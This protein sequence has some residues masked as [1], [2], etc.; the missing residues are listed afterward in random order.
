MAYFSKGAAVFEVF[1]SIYVPAN[2][3]CFVSLTARGHCS[4]Q[5]TKPLEARTVQIMLPFTESVK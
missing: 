1:S 4:P 5:F 2:P 3:V